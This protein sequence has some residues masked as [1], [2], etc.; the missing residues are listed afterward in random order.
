MT[1]VPHWIQH[2][3][4]SCPYVCYA[5]ICRSEPTMWLLSFSMYIACSDLKFQNVSHVNDNLNRVQLVPQGTFWCTSL[6][7]DC[8]EWW[9]FPVSKPRYGLSKAVAERLLF[10]FTTSSF[11]FHRLSLFCFSWLC[12]QNTDQSFGSWFGTPGQNN[13]LETSVAKCIL[14]Y[15]FTIQPCVLPH[16]LT[17][18]V[19]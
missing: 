1:T 15:T 14:I 10:S 17:H 6:W 9:V 3:N 2:T 4:L 11:L 5:C 13:P 7:L 18:S 19:V 16:P 8:G 12:C